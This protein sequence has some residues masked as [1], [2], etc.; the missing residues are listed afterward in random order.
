MQ[1]KGIPTMIYYPLP[2][3]KQ[4]AY[5][6]DIQLPIAEMLSNSVVSLPIGTDMEEEQIKYIIN[7]ILNYFN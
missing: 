7:T 4:N 1:E 6:Q 5:Q 2:L 3:Y